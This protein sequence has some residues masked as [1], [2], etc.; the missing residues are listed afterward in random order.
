M[1]TLPGAFSLAATAHLSIG[2]RNVRSRAF[3]IQLRIV[4]A[5]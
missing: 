3:L 4:A 2:A 1:G 5:P